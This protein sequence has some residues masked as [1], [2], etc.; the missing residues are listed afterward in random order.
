MAGTATLPMRETFNSLLEKVKTDDNSVYTQ[1]PLFA[2][3]HPEH[4]KEIVSLIYRRIKN[5][6]KSPSPQANEVRIKYY[7]V[8]DA[9]L[10]K[11]MPRYIK[12][13]EEIVLPYFGDEMVKARLHPTLLVQLVVLFATWE[14]LLSM[15]FLNEN[16]MKFYTKLPNLVR[17]SNSRTSTSFLAKTGSLRSKI[18]TAM[19]TSKATSST[20]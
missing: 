12:A 6:D 16:L 14:G 11:K 3:N 17:A 19:R 7:Y 20:K 5:L 10:K 15:K 4:A 2:E 1:I 9:I 18:F 8:L 13:F